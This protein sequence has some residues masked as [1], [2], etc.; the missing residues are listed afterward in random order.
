MFDLPVPILRDGKA[1]VGTFILF[2][3]ALRNVPVLFFEFAVAYVAA[4]FRRAA[5]GSRPRL[6]FLTANPR[7]NNAS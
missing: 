7:R 4:A 2:R 5:F 1:N 3:I 6:F